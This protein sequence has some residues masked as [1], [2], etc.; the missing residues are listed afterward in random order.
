[1]RIRTLVIAALILATSSSAWARG[2]G[3][4][5][6]HSITIGAGY[7]SPSDTTAID[8]NP[9]GLTFVTKPRLTGAGSTQDKNFNP[10]TG[11]GG[12]FVGNGM[13]GAGAEVNHLVK[14]GAPYYV[15]GA[16]AAAIEPLSTA[17]GVTC[18]GATDNSIA[19]TCN[20]IGVMITPASNFRIGA[21]GFNLINSSDVK[22]YGFGMSAPLNASSTI[23]VDGS[24]D[25]HGNGTM[26]EPALGIS[27]QALQLMVGYGASLDNKSQIGIRQ[28]T[29]AGLGLKLGTQMHI[30]AYYN[31][32]AKYYLALTLLL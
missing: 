1:M 21:T 18:G 14:N 4:G 11:T 32:L 24:M 28:G 9:A 22:Y 8:E 29:Q 10:W 13:V 12:I 25:S 19:F 6:D 15:E 3:A 26:V 16:L 31:H 30:E 17:F 2:Y 27:V 7:S 5:G 20:N 23:S